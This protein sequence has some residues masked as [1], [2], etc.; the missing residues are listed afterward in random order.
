[1][2][3][4][5]GASSS[6]VKIKMSISTF[7]A[8]PKA[9]GTV[10]GRTSA[11][12]V[13]DQNEAAG[14]GTSPTNEEGELAKP[15]Q[16]ESASS[17]IEK[18]ESTSNSAGKQNCFAASFGTPEARWKFLVDYHLQIFLY[19]AFVV[20]LSI[21]AIGETL[22]EP[23]TEITGRVVPYLNVVFVFLVTGSRIRTEAFI[24][25]LRK[26]HFLF[27]GMF[28]INVYT[29]FL[30]HAWIRLPL[31]PKSFAGGLALFTVAPTTITSGATFVANCPGTSRAS[32]L[33]LLLTVST[34]LIGCFTVPPQ[35]GLVLEGYPSF[36]GSSDTSDVNIDVGKLLLRLVLSL[37]VPSG[38]GKAFQVGMDHKY[39]GSMTKFLKKYK[40]QVTLVSNGSLVMIVWQ[41]VSRA[42]KEITSL[43]IG[44]LLIC[45]VCG[46]LLHIVLWI[47][48]GAALTVLM[49]IVV[50]LRRRSIFKA[51]QDAAMSI[52]VVSPKQDHDDLQKDAGDNS[53]L[54]VDDK[55]AIRLQEVDPM[56]KDLHSSEKD[57]AGWLGDFEAEDQKETLH[58]HRALFLLSS[59]KTLPVSLAVLAGLEEGTLGAAG[60]VAI[61]CIFSHFSQLTMDAFLVSHWKKLALAEKEKKAP[62]DAE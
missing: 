39:S 30:A 11:D 57:T 13:K 17:K 21:P 42:Q 7:G 43:P 55:D 10:D 16:E 50:R 2:N 59:Q 35:L 20:G 27:L 36:S 26:P 47:V 22:S 23:K 15:G 33:A 45:L 48:N 34:N 61:P 62:S 8:E 19:C 4:F 52:V 46:V 18:K 60:L 14:T 6:T 12:K 54:Q 44:D 32:E 37:L 24:A 31:H 38:I 25:A 5:D 29:P 51:V 53:K 58:A 3:G 49:P 28:L 9:P 1:M 41:G 56:K 40:S